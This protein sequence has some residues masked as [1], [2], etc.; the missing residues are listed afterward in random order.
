MPLKKKPTKKQTEKSVKAK[1]VSVKSPIKSKSQSEKKKSPPKL[2]AIKKT[3][4]KKIAQPKPTASG[5]NIFWKVLEMRKQEREARIRAESEGYE[6][7][8]PR[9]VYSDKHAKFSRYAGPR[10]RAA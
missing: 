4:K 6:N 3:E 7:K 9:N 10:R 2:M 1:K 5:G 8:D